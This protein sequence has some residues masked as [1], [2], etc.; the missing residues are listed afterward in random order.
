MR[1]VMVIDQSKCLGCKSCVVACNIE[2]SIETNNNWTEVFD[3]VSG[4]FPNYHREFVPRPCNHCSKPPCV[5]ICPTKASQKDKLTGTVQIDQKRCTGC[6][7]CM[8]ACPYKVRVFNWKKPGKVLN[9]NPASPKRPKGTT[10]KCT[11]CFHKTGKEIFDAKKEGRKHRVEYNAKDAV[12]PACVEKCV[13]KSRIFGDL[14]DPDSFVSRLLSKNQYKVL[15][16]SKG[17]KPNV[18]YIN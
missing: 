4:Q 8:S 15:L 13:G 14:D 6:R 9:E 2:N 17:T 1:L 5:D 12:L 18:F 10:E 7:Y 11:F 16:K 3:M